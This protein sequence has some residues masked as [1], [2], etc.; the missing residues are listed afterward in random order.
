[1][2][3]GEIDINYECERTGLNAFTR[4]CLQQTFNIAEIL[5][6]HGKADKNYVNKSD[7]KSVLVMAVEFRFPK[8][9]DYL[10]GQDVDVDDENLKTK[11]GISKQIAKEQYGYQ[12]VR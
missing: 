3:K 9:V 6:K 2:P 7:G 8:V 11:L 10:L 1:M 12:R 5:L 4:A